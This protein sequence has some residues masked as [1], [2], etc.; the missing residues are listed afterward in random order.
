MIAT[1]RIDISVA[2]RG[3]R[4]VRRNLDGIGKS[5]VGA[6]GAVKL[7]RRSLGALGGILILGAAT[8]TLANFGQEMSTVAAV[9]GATEEQFKSLRDTAKTLGATTR[10]SA[11]QAAEGMTFL[12][13]AGFDTNE[14]LA[15][16]KD[17]L[18]LAQAG[19]LDLGRAA[20]IASN[21]LKG[22]NL[23][24]DETTRIVDVLVT[25][26]N[27]ANTNVE[28]LGQAMSFLAP[29]A[30]AVGVSVENAAAAVGALSDAGVQ[31]TRAGTSLRQ[32]FVKFLDP[33]SKAKRIM[34]ELGIST[35]DLNIKQRGLVP[36]L[37]TLRDSHIE[38]EQAAAL[39]GTRQ[40]ANLLILTKS[41]PKIN[42][43]TEANE[44]SAGAAR[45]VA[46]IMDD[47]LNGA[48]LAVKSAFEAV[49]LAIGDFG[50]DTTLQTAMRSM[51][52]GLRLVA[53]NIDDVIA[54]LKVLAVGFIALK[55]P[56]I[57]GLFRSLAVAMLANPVIAFSAAMIA[58]T[59]TVTLLRDEIA[60]TNDGTIKLIDGFEAASTVLGVSFTQAVN[61][62]GFEFKNL[63]DIWDTFLT[64]FGRGLIVALATVNGA[65]QAMIAAF[66]D[67]P[68]ALKE[69]AGLAW[70]G[71]IRTTQNSLNIFVTLINK[72]LDFLGIAQKAFEPFDLTVLRVKGEEGG[73]I[74]ANAFEK[75][76]KSVIASTISVAD[77]RRDKEELDAFSGIFDDGDNGTTFD[78][79]KIIAAGDKLI[80][81]E[82]GGDKAF[83]ALLK[84]LTMEGELL[85]LN[86]RER[87]IREVLLGAEDEL[88]RKLTDTEKTSLVALAAN[89]FE[90][91][92]QKLILDE[93]R[94]PEEQYQNQ[95]KAL[96]ELL[97]AG[98]IAQ[99]EFNQKRRDLQ[100]AGLQG[101]T[102]F[103]SGI[104]L[105]FLEATKN[106][107]D[108][109]T[110]SKNLITEAFTGAQSVVSNFFKTGKFE[111]DEFF[112]SMIDNLIKLGTQ[113]LFAQALGAF[114]GGGGGGFL[115][116]VG[117]PFASG[118]EFTV[119]AATSVGK[120]SGVDN[121]LVSLTARDGETV[122]VTPPGKRAGGE[123]AAP[124]VN[125]RLT[126]VFPNATNR[127][128]IVDS[129]SQSMV[130]LMSALND[131]GARNG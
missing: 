77:V 84:N 8:R 33:T 29:A 45:K 91:A 23:E 34:D 88:K 83:A 58:L 63:D 127:R 68:R 27:K 11:T 73:G 80:A 7:L 60:L 106:I 43:L 70:N 74:L 49:I 42:E 87:S 103:T 85:K 125:V 57:I 64:N 123:G 71:F 95:L 30:A 110:S 44:N 108:F 104:E 72:A 92:Q 4:T 12:A 25:T 20:D 2:E 1:E 18:D 96:K 41:I 100:I 86:N 24:A 37:E 79:S 131:S 47:N 94:G 105:G 50:A 93:L 101:A 78:A 9:T 56:A 19:A 97:A 16:V 21:V 129:Q 38:L 48:L 67:F 53:A 54:A 126:Q 116:G 26:S 61:K 98:T 81:A 10:F 99:E 13:R 121:R 46:T 35:A 82:S 102:D 32:I 55:L 5:A 122:S 76:F 130:A 119:S 28:Q 40:A 128:E 120:V 39:V 69:L 111:A 3:S 22:F 109:A 118:G 31:A 112:Q 89:N 107:E 59:A 52:S 113:Q 14:V 36:V 90:L 62:I 6:Q 114:S 117:G 65:V 66:D 15:S 75:G 124:Q 17:T 115:S 51:A